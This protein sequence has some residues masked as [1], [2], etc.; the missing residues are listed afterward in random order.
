[1][2]RHRERMTKIL[3]IVLA[4]SLLLALVLPFLVQGQ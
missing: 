3:G 1:M 4:I 2:F